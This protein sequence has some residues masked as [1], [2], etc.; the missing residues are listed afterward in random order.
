MLANDTQ[1]KLKQ[2][3]AASLA[4]TSPDPIASHSETLRSA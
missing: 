3:L 2:T 4:P 1:R